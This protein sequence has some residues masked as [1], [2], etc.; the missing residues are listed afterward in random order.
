MP[1]SLIQR[2][3]A[4]SLLAARHKLNDITRLPDEEMLGRLKELDHLMGL[5]RYH[6]FP[7]QGTREPDRHGFHYEQ[8]EGA[9]CTVDWS[10]PD[11]CLLNIGGR[12]LCR[13]HQPELE[14]GRIRP[15][16][17][18]PPTKEREALEAS[19]KAALAKIGREELRL[20]NTRIGG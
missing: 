18:T 14:D 9:D 8:C 15:V 20:V 1:D 11:G 2:F 6:A 12:W 19:R 3:G 5:L 7:K 13:D 10:T 16:G 17:W 4:T